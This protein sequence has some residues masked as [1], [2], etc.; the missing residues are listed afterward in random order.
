MKGCRSKSL[1]CLCVP[2]VRSL[3]SV[4][5]RRMTGR[6]VAVINPQVAARR[7]KEILCQPHN[8]AGAEPKKWGILPSAP[9]PGIGE[10]Q[11][12]YF[13]DTIQW[14]FDVASFTSV[15]HLLH[16]SKTK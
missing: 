11:N 1:P 8:T 2:C 7:E 5:R 15:A 10:V 14:H 16:N 4:S 3:P 6:C 9:L 12:S 13:F